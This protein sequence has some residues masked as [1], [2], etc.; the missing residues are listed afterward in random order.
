MV[1]PIGLDTVILEHCRI[2]EIIESGVTDGVDE[3]VDSHLTRTLINRVVYD[4]PPQFFTEDPR[5]R[6]EAHDTLA[7]VSS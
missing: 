7:K 3:I 1:I 5:I 4:Y 6:E 2:R